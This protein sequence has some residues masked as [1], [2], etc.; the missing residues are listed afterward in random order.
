MTQKPQRL[1]G[2][3]RFGI[4]LVSVGFFLSLPPAAA[5][6]LVGLYLTWPDDPTTGIVVNW[7]NLYPRN[8]DTVWYRDDD[9][10]AWRSA[11]AEQSEVEPSSLQLRRADLTDLE[12]DHTYTFGIGDKP[13]AG[14]G[15]R[16]RTMPAR[17]ERPVRFVAGGDMMHSREMLDRMTKQA[18]ALDPDFALLGGDLAYANGVAATRWIDWLGSWMTAGVAKDRRL[19]PIVTA[20]GNHETRGGRDGDPRKDAPYYYGLFVRP[21]GR[22]F[23]AADVGDYLSLVVLDSGH[24]Q[25]VAG[26][27]AEWLAAALAAR[28]R[29]RFLF[30]TYHFPAYG[31]SKSPSGKLPIDNPRAIEIRE[32]W[33]PH[34]ERHGATAVFEHDHHTYKRSHRIRAGERDDENGLLYLGD[35]A[36]GVGTRPVPAP[37]TAWW[38]ARAEA[39]NHIWCLDL[40]PDSTVLA[41]AI[42]ERGEVF[43][44][45]EITE[46]RTK[47][48]EALLEAT[49]N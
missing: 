47:P 10:D 21:G 41:R 11:E 6:D 37:G 7:V 22:S 27:Q 19:I 44:E 2:P 30:V 23:F 39:K 26:P 20:I 13:A 31:T 42:D 12:P 36:W 29:Q 43:D 16:F 38:L 24:T 48:R 3:Q 9:T 49:V 15:W 17:L 4:A 34:L 33:V 1:S 35:G 18:A 40:Q 14:K 8:T 25:K 32:H 45:V 46:P 28:E 5:Q